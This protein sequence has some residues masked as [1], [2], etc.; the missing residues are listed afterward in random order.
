M[1]S[2]EQ[3]SLLGGEITEA[4]GSDPVPLAA[5]G[6]PGQAPAAAPAVP[7]RE[8]APMLQHYVTLKRRYPEHLLL[9]Q[10]GDFFEIF[11]DDA[12]RAADALNIR[13]TSRNKEEPSPIPM[14]GFPIHAID[15]YLPK[16]LQAGYS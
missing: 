14:C 2:A 3:L 4:P 15:N 12:P 16:L 13:L 9:F 6:E 5:T 1:E 7:E 10:V 8:L 11:F